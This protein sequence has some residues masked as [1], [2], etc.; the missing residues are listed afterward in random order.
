MGMTTPTMQ[1]MNDSIR[2][3]PSSIATDMNQ[4]ST[5]AGSI[6]RTDRQAA[7][8]RQSVTNFFPSEQHERGSHSFSARDILS[9]N[10]GHEIKHPG[11][12]FTT[13]PYLLPAEGGNTNSNL[14]LVRQQN[15]TEQQKKQI[16]EQGRPPVASPQIMENQDDNTIPNTNI[17]GDGDNPLEGNTEN[18]YSFS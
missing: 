17:R 10:T 18:T 11:N 5:T 6:S 2:S 16:G 4:S 8:L 3:Q 13:N 14:T 12:F 7:F 15:H 1:G 9:N